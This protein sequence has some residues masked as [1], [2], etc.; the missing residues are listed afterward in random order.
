LCKDAWQR[1]RK[2]TLKNI[3]DMCAARKNGLPGELATA[4]STAKAN[5]ESATVALGLADTAALCGQ[6]A[7]REN[8]IRLLATRGDAKAQRILAIYIPSAE[9]FKSLSFTWSGLFL[10]QARTARMSSG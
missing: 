1:W 7:L 4:L 3:A 6:Y 9:A 5:Q 2:E 10:E 8:A